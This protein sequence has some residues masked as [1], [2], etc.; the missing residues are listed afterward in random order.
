MK[1]TYFGHVVNGS[2]KIVNRQMFD[3][4]LLQYEGKE[5]SIT[6]DKK[7]KQ[8]SSPQNRYYWGCM[9]PMVMEGLIHMGHQVDTEI[10]H[11]FLKANFRKTII[12]N[13]ETG[14]TYTLPGSTQTLT[15]SAF[16][17]FKAQI[18]RWAAEYLNIN[19]PDPNEQ[20]KIELN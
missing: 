7:R 12:V 9:I 15:T 2:L 14:E 8:R 5:V 19:I 1:I 6:V 10:T 20:I 18:Q 17:D 4:E 11:E 13:E 16:M 3:G